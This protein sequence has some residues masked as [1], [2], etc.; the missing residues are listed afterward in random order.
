MSK[1][2]PIL[3]H[4]ISGSGHT[5]VL[6]HGF[7][8]SSRYWDK[9][10]ALLSRRYRVVAIDLLGFGKSPKPGCSRYDYDAQLASINA[11]L[12]VVGV[13]K[14]ILIGHSM[15][16]LIAL[17]YARVFP[18]RVK[19]LLLANMPI[20]MNT[21]QA[22]ENILGENLLYW[23]ALRPGLHA[24][25]WPIFRISAALGLLPSK[26]IEAAGARKSYIFQST[27]ISRLRSLRNVI[28]AAKIE[29]DLRALEMSTTILSG[30]QDTRAKYL[31]VL[32]RL[33]LNSNIVLQ[34]MAGGHHFPLTQP[35]V[36]EEIIGS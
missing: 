31:D 3:H 33:R 8:A 17:R 29:A 12:E 34:N 4:E 2:I 9:V 20:L 27:G 15:G 18:S 32:P 25:I 30:L 36:F 14:F 22:K 35:H 26:N 6:L 7:M 21:K 24:V 16:A 10:I 28:Y 23:L 13:K 1:Q 19:R 11:T 5:V